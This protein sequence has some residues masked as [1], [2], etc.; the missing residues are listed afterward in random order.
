MDDVTGSKRVF[1]IRLYAV[2]D[3]PTVDPLTG[4]RRVGVLSI[5]RAVPTLINAAKTYRCSRE[6]NSLKEYN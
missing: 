6:F 5:M 4:V 3:F 2:R 1:G